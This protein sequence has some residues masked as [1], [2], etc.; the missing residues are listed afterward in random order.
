MG[1]VLFGVNNTFNDFLLDVWIACDPLWHDMYS[2]VAGDFHRW[3]W[4]REIC[5]KYGYHYIEGRWGD[6]LSTNPEYIHY[7]HSS[8]YQALNLA[9]HYGCN[10][11]FFV[12]YDMHYRGD[13]RHYFSGL[14][15]ENGEY[16]QHLRKFSTFDGL[17]KCYETIA[18]QKGL[19]EIYNATPGSALTC[20]ES[21]DLIQKMDEL[22][23][24]S[25]GEL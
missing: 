10:P 1:A 3:H 15:D 25:G 4:D 23:Y 7:G 19:P 18:E 11:I 14:S 9:V 6:G 12:G 5:E 24:L 17:I 16:P 21:V 2:P 8:G 22:S 13:K 20:F